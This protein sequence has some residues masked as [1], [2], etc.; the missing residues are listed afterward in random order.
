MIKIICFVKLFHISKTYK[1]AEL[2]QRP[3][4]D[5]PSIW[6]S[7]KVSRVFTNA[8]GYFSRNSWAYPGTAQIFFISGTGKATS[9]QLCTHLLSID[10]NKRPLKFR[11]KWPWASQESRNFPGHPYIGRIARSS[12]R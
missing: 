11:E 1:T 8:R 2:A 12:L 10:R 4:R 3:P 7:W 9:F 5:A 6:V